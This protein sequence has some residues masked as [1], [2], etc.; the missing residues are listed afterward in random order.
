MGRNPKVT[1]K[2]KKKHKHHDAGKLDPAAGP[3]LRVRQIR[4]GIGHPPGIRKTL[5]ALGLRHHQDVATHTNHA[6]IRGML[7]QVRHLVQVTPVKE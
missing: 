5:E 7:Y 2:W 1:R 6:A 3:T 4:S